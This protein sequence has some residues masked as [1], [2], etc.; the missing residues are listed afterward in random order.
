VHTEARD[1]ETARALQPAERSRLV[2]RHLVDKARRAHEDPVEFLDF[3]ARD[4]MQKKVGCAPHQELMLRFVLQAKDMNGFRGRTVA[5]AP[6]E[7]GKT[8]VA[9][10][11][12][13]LW[14]IGRNHNLTGA[15]VSKTQDQAKK[16]L[17][18]IRHTIESSVEYHLVFPDVKRSTKEGDPWTQTAITVERKGGG[19]D[20]TLHAYG[21]DSP[22][23]TGSRLAWIIC[24]DLLC[25][26]NTAT[27]EQREKVRIWFHKYVLSRLLPGG[28]IIMIN[29]AV[30]PED[31]LHD[32]EK[33]GWPTMRM[34]AYGGIQFSGTTFGLDGEAGEDLVESSEPGS[35][36]CVLTKVKGEPDP[37]RR[38]LF[39]ARFT[40]KRLEELRTTTLPIVFAANYRSICRDDE[41]AMCKEEYIEKCKALARKIGLHAPVRGK[42]EAHDGYQFT[43][44]YPVFHGVDLAVKKGEKRDYVSIFTLE[45]RD[46]P[47]HGVAG[48]RVVLDVEFGQWPGPEIVR[49]IIAR[50]DRYGGEVIVEDNGA[51][52]YIRQFTLE[53]RTD[54]LCVPYVTTATKHHAEYGVPGIFGE[55]SQGAWALPNLP[56]GQVPYRGIAR[57]I[58]ECLY[59]EPDKHTGD[60]LMS[61]FFARERARKFQ[62]AMMGGGKGRRGSLGMQLLAR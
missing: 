34:D 29:S 44:A 7:H 10:I 56:N 50:Y 39:P 16:T 5:I 36:E 14:Q 53:Q 22:A 46:F 12:T 2:A 31:L 42:N 3:V 28:T 45:L 62:A 17:N 32:L 51:Q 25:E 15:I 4:E 11:L 61:S 8:H 57:F 52:A 38:V 59:Y 43:G 20:P 55:M 13:T 40:L 6:V 24:D 49:K 9:G 1:I 26:E 23:I 54:L 35:D 30:H 47:E 33:L 18:A 19:K 41:S 27:P 37:D 58:H 48:V 21:V 60:V